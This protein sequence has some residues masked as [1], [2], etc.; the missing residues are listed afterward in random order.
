[1]TSLPNR[2]HLKIKEVAAYYGVC[3]K[4]I[5]RWGKA[6]ELEIW[7]VG[8]SKR[9]TRESVEVRDQMASMLARKG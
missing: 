9:V 6:G 3:T 7:T 4:T 1:M 5:R 2:P 8:G